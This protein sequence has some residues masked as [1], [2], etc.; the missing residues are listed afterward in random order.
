MGL[1][2]RDVFQKGLAFDRIEG[3]FAIE[4]GHAYTSNLLLEGPA[5][6]IGIVGRAGLAARDYD[7]TAI[8]SANIGRSLPIAG[9][10]AGGP[11]VAAAM[12]L[13]SQIFKKP[14][15]GMTQVYYHVDGSWEDPQV[16]RV[17]AA[18]T[19]EEPAGGSP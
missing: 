4:D 3:D 11:Q 19:T 7:Q 1:D 14:L 17:A 9:F 16:E 6:D 2:F 15:R 8:V 18:E 10:L 13:F 12:L 5:A